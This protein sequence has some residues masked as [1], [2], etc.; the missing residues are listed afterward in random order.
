VI[1]PGD[2][3]VEIGAAFLVC[4]PYDNVGNQDPIQACS[5]TPK[6]DSRAPGLG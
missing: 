2:P 4:G 1:S 5:A 3:D 6:K